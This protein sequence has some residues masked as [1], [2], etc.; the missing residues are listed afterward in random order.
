VLR[1]L[2]AADLREVGDTLSE[3]ASNAVAGAVSR[4]A[5]RHFEELFGTRTGHG[6]AMAMQATAGLEDPAT[7]AASCE[8]LAKRLLA[9]WRVP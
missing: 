3:L 6:A 5:R 2:R 1:I 8:V 9:S 4:E 7:I